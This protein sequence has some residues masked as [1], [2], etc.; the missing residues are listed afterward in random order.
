MMNNPPQSST[1]VEQTPATLIP[2]E[3]AILRTVAYSDIFDYPLTTDEIQRYLIGA[4]SSP[5]DL[6]ATLN[7]GRLVPY[8]LHHQGG[9]FSLPGRLQIV[10]R[11]LKRKTSAVNLWSKALGYGTRI[12]H[13]PFVRMVAVT[14][15]LAMDNEPGRDLDYLIVTEAG[16]LWLCRGL[17]M[18]LVR[19]AARYGDQLCPNYFLS[20]NALVFEQRNLYS[21]HE[22]V[23]M[24]PLYGLDLYWKIRQLNGWTADYLP[25]ASGLPRGDIPIIEQPRPLPLKSLAENVLRTPPGEWVDSWEMQRKQRKF[26]RIYPPSR[27]ADFCADWCKGHFGEYGQRTL[28][29][30]YDRLDRLS[31]LEANS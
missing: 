10:E 16:R 4:N 5:D 13:L 19:W 20:E 18:L 1:Q 7:S 25:N 24:V 27:E 29:A 28:A 31:F 23:Q 8:A 26:K 6:Y 12:A 14:G 2:I 17:V 11:R 21:A 22:L 3:Q 15:A 30:Y 9:F